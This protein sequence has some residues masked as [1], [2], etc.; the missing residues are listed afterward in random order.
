MH[1]FFLV[2]FLRHYQ[3]TELCLSLNIYGRTTSN[4]ENKFAK[5]HG[6][7]ATNKLYIRGI[8]KQPLNLPQESPREYDRIYRL[9]L[10]I[11]PLQ[12]NEVRKTSNRNGFS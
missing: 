12:Y 4:F 3:C 9:A 2:L 8:Y 1:V 6:R 7:G 11:S 10:I 5:L